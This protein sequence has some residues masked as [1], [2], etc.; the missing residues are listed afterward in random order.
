MA[1]GALAIDEA[2]ARLRSFYGPLAV[3]PHDPFMMYIWEVLNFQSAPAKRDAALG[4]LRR[5]P[6]LPPDSIS[7]A[8]PKK[9]EAAVHLA[10]PYLDERIRVLKAGANVFRRHPDATRR[11]QGTAHFPRAHFQLNDAIR[12]RSVFTC[13]QICMCSCL[14][15]SSSGTVASRRYSWRSRSAAAK[16]SRW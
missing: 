9:L 13:S 11:L 7:K 3:P 15:C 16:S 4:A 2:V 5:I 14:A 1:Q 6:A 12:R 8:V 10:G